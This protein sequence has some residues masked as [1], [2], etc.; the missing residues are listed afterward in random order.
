MSTL[1]ETPVRVDVFTS[2]S[3]F[4]TTLQHWAAARIDSP[5][6]LLA[7]FDDA[8]KQLIALGGI[9][10]GILFAIGSSELLKGTPAGHRI[11]FLIMPLIVM[12]FCAAKV[13]C[14]V[15]VQ[16]EAMQTFNLLFRA[17]RPPGVPDTELTAAMHGWCSGVDRLVLRKHRWLKAA[18][19]LFLLS[20]ASAV[21]FLFS[22]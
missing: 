11:P 18:N 2:A 7:R 10:Q 1:T 13:I 9:L 5:L 19:W 8:A 22:L 3:T 4:E 17:G 15:P 20:S 16:M 21:L 12:I 6:Q 14:T